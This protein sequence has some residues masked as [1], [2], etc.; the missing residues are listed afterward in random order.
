MA[1]E[2]LNDYITH[3]INVCFKLISTKYSSTH[4]EVEIQMSSHVFGPKKNSSLVGHVY[5]LDVYGAM[6]PLKAFQAAVDQIMKGDK[7]WRPIL[8]HDPDHS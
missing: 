7:N 3:P 1:E 5:V 6:S 2:K 8:Y 4:W